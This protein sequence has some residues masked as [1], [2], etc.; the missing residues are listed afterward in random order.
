MIPVE[1]EASMTG[2]CVGGDYETGATGVG[3]K[4]TLN[5]PYCPLHDEFI[6][7]QVMESRI[8]FRNVQ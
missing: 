3:N 8:C 5:I 4:Y 6:K 2:G 1:V 7:S